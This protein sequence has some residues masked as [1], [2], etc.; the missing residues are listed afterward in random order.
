[1]RTCPTNGILLKTAILARADY[2][3]REPDVPALREAV[4]GLR[5]D[6]R[7]MREVPHSFG[8]GAGLGGDAACSGLAGCGGEAVANGVH[9]GPVVPEG[10]AGVGGVGFLR[11]RASPAF[12][13]S[14][15]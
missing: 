5:T 14:V 7:P 8:A 15:T 3:A 9:G 2:Q 10:R 12:R 13:A 11:A 6:A 4:A 1:M